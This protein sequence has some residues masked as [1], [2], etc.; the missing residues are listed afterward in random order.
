MKEQ[1]LQALDA[2]IAQRPCACGRCK[3]A[4]QERV[5]GTED[6][7]VLGDWTDPRELIGARYRCLVCRD[8]HKAAL[9]LRGRAALR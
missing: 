7:E 3:K 2:M 6:V 1:K 5:A 9:I 8:V 4:Q